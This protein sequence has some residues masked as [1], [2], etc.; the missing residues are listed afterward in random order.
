M[1]SCPSFALLR[2]RLAHASIAVSSPMLPE[3]FVE[4]QVRIFALRKIFRARP[5]RASCRN[6][7]VEIHFPVEAGASDVFQTRT[8]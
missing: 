3:L 8:V 1:L 5:V 7:I 6:R 4:P 2:R